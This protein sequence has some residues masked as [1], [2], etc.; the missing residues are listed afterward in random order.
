[1][2][3]IDRLKELLFGAEKQVLDSI[4]ERVEK[5]ELRSADVA[6][7][8]AESIHTSHQQGG[9]LREALRKPVGE[10][11]REEFHHD[12]QT[13]G[14]ALYPVMG[15][16]IRKSIM[17]ALRS[18]SQQINAAVENSLTPKGLSWRWQAWRAG[19]PFGDFIVQKTLLYRVEQ[20]YLISRENGLLVGHVQHETAKIK[21]SDAVSAMFTAI[22]DFIKESFTPDRTGRLESADMG[23]FT[24]WAVHGPH[25]LLVCVIRGVPPRSL[26]GRLA[27]I[28]ERIHFRYGDAIRDYSGDPSTVP[29]V[30]TELAACLQLQEHQDEDTSARKVNWPIMVLLLLLLGAAVFFAAKNWSRV[31]ELDRLRTALDETPGIYVTGVESKRDTITVK[32]MRDPLAPRIAEVADAQGITDKGIDA[33]MA[34]F[35]S[36]DPRLVLQRAESR[37]GTPEG[38]DLAIDGTRLVVTGAA[39]LDWR[40]DVEG[41]HRTI[42]GIDAVEFRTP[43]P[44]T[45]KPESAPPEPAVDPRAALLRELDERIESMSQRVFY[46]SGGTTLRDDSSAVMPGYLDDLLALEMDL[47]DLGQQLGVTITGFVDAVG[48]NEINSVVAPQRAER[49]A[50]MLRERGLQGNVQTQSRVPA[51]GD[52]LTVDPSLRRVL[53]ELQRG[54]LPAPQ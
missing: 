18:F 26:R 31:Q 25:A 33:Q 54:A 46:F 45:V 9:D 53:I 22:Q 5:R 36:L 28:L 34:S 14:D 44:E 37:F 19:V 42:P 20:A 3:D 51:D 7:V 32:G 13:Y 41:G 49:I 2:S 35:Y 48:G 21:D 4:T 10:C 17:Q 8:L 52:D 24:L 38:V 30:E 12:P 50:G 23:D 43:P 11:L 40:A 16:A 27:G 6:D 1:M 39:P 15:P 47:A 29:N